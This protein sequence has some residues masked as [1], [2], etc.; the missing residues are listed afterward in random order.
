M[1]TIYGIYKKHGREDFFVA[2]QHY[3]DHVKSTIEDTLSEMESRWYD[4][5]QTVTEAEKMVDDY[6]NGLTVLNDQGLACPNMGQM[7]M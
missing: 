3:S 4:S 2:A 7:S 6:N 5:S 1:K